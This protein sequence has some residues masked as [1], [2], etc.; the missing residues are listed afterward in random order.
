MMLKQSHN[1]QHNYQQGKLMTHRKSSIVCLSMMLALSMNATAE[2]SP[3]VASN[4]SQTTKASFDVASHIKDVNSAVW[5]ENMKV[6]NAMTVKMQ[7]LLDWNNAN[8]G[9]I[10]GGWG[11]NSKQALQNFQKISGLTVTGRMD[12]DT[13]Q[14]LNSTLD[15]SKPILTTYTIS[16]QDTAIDVRAL[17]AGFAAQA[18]QKSLPYQSVAEMLAE[19]FHMDIAYIKKLNPNKKFE[20]GDVIY[21]VNQPYELTQSIDKI[22]AVEA[23]KTVYAYNNDTLVASYPATIGN[24]QKAAPIGNHTLVNKIENPWYKATVTNNGKEISYMLPPGA[25]NPIGVLWLGLSKP[26]CGISGMELPE[27]VGRKDATGCIKLT[28]WDVQEVAKNTSDKAQVE[29]R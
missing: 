29:I 4:T 22:I 28:N 20:A 21:V 15:S 11:A 26:S 27:I 8:V 19:R 2:E 16:K 13:W 23:D 24:T 18:K 1:Y 3:A 25:N 14:A 6:N 12:A 10:D 7:V 9:P 5:S 17:P